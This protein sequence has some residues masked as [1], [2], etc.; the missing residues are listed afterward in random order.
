MANRNTAGMGFTPVSTLGNAPAVSGQSKYKID[1]GNATNIYL[2]TQVQTAAGYVTVG[3]ASS[4][5]NSSYNRT[6][7]TSNIHNSRNS[8]HNSQNHHQ[9]QPNQFRLPDLRKPGSVYFK[10]FIVFGF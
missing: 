10:V 6:N 2:G 8:H 3:T 5:T 1:N 9:N 4:K 7:P